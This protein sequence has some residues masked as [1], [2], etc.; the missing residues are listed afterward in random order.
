MEIETVA[1]V[2]V[3]SEEYFVWRLDDIY[4]R[5]KYVSDVQVVA[6]GSGAGTV[7]MIC[8]QLAANGV[9]LWSDVGCDRLA[10]RACLYVYYVTRLSSLCCVML[11]MC[12][13][14]TICLW[15][16]HV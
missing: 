11:A 9:P 15:C 16:Y 14:G 6:D 4:D 13:F 7:A 1:L 5:V 10:L 8:K 3:P 12:L 2:D